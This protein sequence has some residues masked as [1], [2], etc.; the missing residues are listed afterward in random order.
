MKYFD[1]E[2][3]LTLFGKISCPSRCLAHVCYKLPGFDRYDVLT[4]RKDIMLMI[5]NLEYLSFR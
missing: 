2:G 1:I 3:M 5:S 4:D